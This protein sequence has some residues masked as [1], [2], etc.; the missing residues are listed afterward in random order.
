MRLEHPEYLW[1]LAGIP[2]LVMSFMWAVSRRKKQLEKIGSHQLI[3]QLIPKRSSS[4]K[5]LRFIII[6]MA[7]ACLIV[8]RA[9][10]QVGTKQETV[11]RKGVDIVIAL[12]LSASMQAED[13]KP[14]RIERSKQFIY[15]LL[16]KFQNDRVSFI[17]F[18]GNAYLQMPLTIDYSAFELYLRAVNTDIIPTQGTA[19]G[20]ALQLAEE[21]FDAGE[22][23]HKALILISDGENHDKAAIE[24]AKESNKNGTKIYTIGVGTPKG[25]PIPTYNKHGQQVDYKKDKE[26]SIVLSK[27]NEKMLQEIAL[28]GGGQYYRLSRGRETVKEV[29]KNIS[30]ME[31]KEIEEQIYTDYLDLFQFFLFFGLVLIVIESLISTR[32]SQMW[33]KLKLFDT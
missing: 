17:I 4:R 18:A 26:G 33:T 14:N 19:I 9:N 21:A 15:S 6:I 24:M 25:G 28:N 1:L 11:K 7:M 3:Q 30:E 16:D 29:M 31:T 10:P 27:L 32:R 13:I 20:D 2:I 23:K 5:T 22:K 8:G 12:D